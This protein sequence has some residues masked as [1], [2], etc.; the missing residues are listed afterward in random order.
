MKNLSHLS[1]TKVM[2]V[3][4]YGPRR[5]GVGGVILKLQILFIGG[6]L[7]TDGSKNALINGLHSIFMNQFVTLIGLRLMRGV[8]GQ[9]GVFPGKENGK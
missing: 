8:D 5:V 9:V 1:K 4:S 3:R 6:A 7:R 2:A